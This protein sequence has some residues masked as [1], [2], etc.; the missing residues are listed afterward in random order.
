[1]SRHQWRLLIKSN[2]GDEYRS[3]V[4]LASSKERLS[5][6]DVALETQA[7]QC[8]RECRVLE[9]LTVH[10]SNFTISLNRCHSKC[11]IVSS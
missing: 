5:I 7:V 4:S 6:R 2:E 9:V 11:S 10:I 8:Q 1:M 3:I